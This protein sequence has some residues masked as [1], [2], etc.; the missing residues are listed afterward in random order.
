MTN[1]MNDDSLTGG[2]Q[3]APKIIPLG[4]FPLLCTTSK[5]LALQLQLALHTGKKQILF[6]ANTNFIVQ[7][8]PL[9]ERM[10]KANT[11]IVNDGIGVN[12]ATWLVHRCNFPEN[13]PGTDFIPYYL[14]QTRENARVFLLG[15]K[16]EVALRAAQT[17]QNEYGVNVVGCC[18]GYDEAR[19]AQQVV[20]AI[21]AS[22]A[23][24]LL[25]AMGNPAQEK[26]IL[27]HYDALSVPVM[28]GV[29]ALFDFWAGDKPRAPGIVRKL[30]LE[31]LYRLCLEP[32]RLMR[33]YTLDIAVF[34]A[35]CL[36]SGKNYSAATREQTH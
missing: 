28:M 17:L 2:T 20:A 1:P 29:G 3:I 16:P 26:W 21:N 35:L 18:N 27:D 30:H 31:W 14:Q 6:F 7:C 36:R 8:Q 12:I 24:V 5:N 32:V 15:G 33:R 19:D 34:L 9:K 13:L 10:K 4:G 25:V 22:Q 23:T 11:V